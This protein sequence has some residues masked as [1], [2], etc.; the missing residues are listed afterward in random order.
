MLTLDDFGMA[1]YGWVIWPLGHK[2]SSSRW[3]HDIHLAPRTATVP[4]KRDGDMVII[5]VAELVPGDVTLGREKN[6]EMGHH[7]TD[8]SINLLTETCQI[9]EKHCHI[10]HKAES[11]IEDWLQ[12]LFSTAL[13]A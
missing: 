10:C 9:P 3:R 12:H 11:S 1:G 13:P 8:I 4:V 6:R 2:S 7:F 5:P